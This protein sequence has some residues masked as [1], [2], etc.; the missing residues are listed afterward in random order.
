MEIRPQDLRLQ[1]AKAK[2]ERQTN[3]TLWNIS[4]YRGKSESRNRGGVLKHL[5]FPG[6]SSS[7]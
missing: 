2:Y 4:H 1:E 3:K 5:P 6:V 7:V